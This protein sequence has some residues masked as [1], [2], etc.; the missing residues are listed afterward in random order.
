MAQSAAAKNQGAN[1]ATKTDW[2]F[3]SYPFLIE[4]RVAAFASSTRIKIG[5]L[6][7]P[8]ALLRRIGRLRLG[9]SRSKSLGISQRENKE[10]L[11]DF[12]TDP[13]VVNVCTTNRGFV[14]R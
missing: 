2:D 10:K 8:P 3:T 14:G 5:F 6:P 9:R 4:L 1:R 11:S 13:R 7:P 12:T